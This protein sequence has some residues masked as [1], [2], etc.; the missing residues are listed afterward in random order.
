LRG[1][2]CFCG[3]VVGVMART[4]G[5]WGVSAAALLPFLGHAQLPAAAMHSP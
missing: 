1:R 3:G 2:R 4:R 5:I